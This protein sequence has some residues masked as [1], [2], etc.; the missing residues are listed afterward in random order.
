M[1]RQAFVDGLDGIL[2]MDKPKG[3][4]SHDV[5]NIVRR[6]LNT[7]RVGHA[8]TLD[9][10]ATGV[11]IILVGKATKK[12]DSLLNEDKDYAVT[13]RLG[14]ATDTGDA[15][16]KVIRTGSLTG[17]SPGMVKDAIMSF[18]GESEQVPP[19][20][21]AIKQK[22]ETL[23]KLARKGIEVAREPR[24]IN[25]KEMRI[26]DISLPDVIFDIS[27]SKGTYVRQLC[28]DIG[29]RLGCAGHMAELRRTR[30]GKYDISQAVALDKLKPADLI[31]QF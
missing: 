15:S 27:C 8:G 1:I 26:K 14:S 23:Y 18:A 12:S 9:P 20:Y 31:C 7:K 11:L 22:G 30:S 28:Q 29:E 16:G 6:V 5:V 2:V 25:I 13:L 3:M 19:M 17:I 21:S 24:R 10:I 4:T